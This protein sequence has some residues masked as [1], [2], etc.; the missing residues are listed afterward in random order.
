MARYLLRWLRD[1]RPVAREYKTN[2]VRILREQIALK[3]RNDLRPDEYYYYRLQDPTM[4][5]EKKLTYLGQKRIR[6]DWHLFV[7][8]RYHFCFHNKLVFKH[9][10]RS[11]GLPVAPYYGF[12]HPHL[13]RSVEG[14]P[15]RNADDLAAWMAATDVQ[16]P[17]FK[18]VESA[19]G[20]MVL[21]MAGRKPDDPTQF[22]DLQSRAHTPEQIVAYMTDPEKLARAYSDHPTPVE[23]FL[24]EQRLQQHPALTELASPTLCCARIVTMT[25]LDGRVELF[26]GALKFDLDSQGVDNTSRGAANALIDLAT[27]KLGVGLVEKH[28][29][30][31]KTVTRWPGKEHDFTGV[32]QPFWDETVALVTQAATV[33]PEAHAIGWDVAFTVDGPY[34]VEANAAWGTFHENYG[35]D[36][37]YGAYRDLIEQIT[38]RTSTQE[39]DR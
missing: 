32:Q 13:G 25:M 10:F 12:F 15:L 18:P 4:P 39:L 16:E 7:P 36:V 35:K 27:G 33:L 24:I 5:W 34:L 6:R 20:Q 37:L 11:M 9:W 19:E 1:S 38:A 17:V 31:R 8:P 28:G 2:M 21:V 26:E 23:T 30:W 29:D 3:L 14:L 22:V